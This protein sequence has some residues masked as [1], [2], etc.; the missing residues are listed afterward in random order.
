[1]TKAVATAQ[2]MD[3]LAPE[4]PWWLGAYLGGFVFLKKAKVPV[5]LPCSLQEFHDL[6]DMVIESE[7]RSLTIS[8]I[9]SVIDTPKLLEN[10]DA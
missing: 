5:M 4:V 9:R 7:D 10:D 6:L 1:M 2:Q 8:Q 3:L